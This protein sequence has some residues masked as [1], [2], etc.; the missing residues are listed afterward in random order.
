MNHGFVNCDDPHQLTSN[1]H[2]LSSLTWT[3][4]E[5]SFSAE[6]PSSPLTFLAY[7]F[8]HSL[9]GLEPGVYHFMS[10]IL[11]IANSLLLFFVLNRMTG[12]FVKSAFVSALFA[13]HPMNV[14]SVAWVAE[15]NNVLSG[16]FF[17]LTL[18]T[19]K[20][21]TEQETWKRYVL[22]LF[23]F[24]LG[25]LAK[26]VLMTLPFMLFL[27]DLWPLKRIQIERRRENSNSRGLVI[28]GTPV[29]R[30]VVE[31]IPFLVL[32]LISLAS[33]LVGANKRMGLYNPE[34]VPM[35][36]R[37][38]N[39][40]VT[41]IKYLLK[42]FW[43]HDLALNYPYPSM[44]PSWQVIGAGIVLMLI[45]VVVFRAVLSRSYLLVGWL[46]FLGGLVPFLGIFQAGLWPEMADRYAYLTYIGI[47]IALTWGITDLIVKDRYSRAIL[48]IAG[49]GVILILMVLTW[50]QVS[51]WKNS[52][53]LF[54]RSVEVT[55]NNYAAYNNLGLAL[56]DKGDINGAIRSYREAL[57]I[58]PTYSKSY[59]NLGVALAEQKD[60]QGALEN[61]TKA[62]Q[63]EPNNADAH[64]SL[65][66]LLAGIGKMDEAKMHFDEAMRINPN[67]SEAHNNLGNLLLNK[68]SYDEAVMHYTEALKINPH[69]AEV[70]NNLGT[71]YI[72]KGNMKKAVEFYKRSLREKPDYS[73]AIEN[74]KRARVNQQKL[75]DISMKIRQSIQADPGKPAPYTKLG[76]IY[77]QLGEYDEAIG[78]YQKAISIQ[79]SYL[80]ALY[81]L[82]IVYSN[83]QEYMRALDVLQK[84]RKIQPENPEAY[85]NT[86]CI[87][88]KQ[89]K[90]DKAIMWLKQS[91]EKGFDNWD[92]LNKDPDLDKIR[93]T[94]F[95]GELLKKH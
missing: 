5:W 65:G 79:G 54:S 92:L 94:A 62:I 68:G 87:Y 6:S 18:L 58:K 23:V 32:S 77:R 75:Q 95:M 84:I 52:E 40:I 86:A 28:R 69:Q 47:F 30:L 4:L 45:T 21:Y 89:G 90:P 37:F 66:S 2:V 67:S 20:F 57:N 56:F 12:E 70:Y 72:L 13:L 11:H 16:L 42:L 24:E 27:L 1:T 88:A 19:Y 81:G 25:L 17:M 39:A 73:D 33:S 74:L 29:F 38:S 22:A 76:D 71:A 60:T 83:T 44:I 55:K 91:I 14:E 80:Q 63:L 49:S 34:I 85:Y 78:Q 9:F 48:N 35:G 36:L 61:Y 26:P 15:L 93:N 51:F 3:N 53:T 8:C 43:P 50:N 59:I 41:S 10:L 64:T 82:V 46:W 7:N 31:K